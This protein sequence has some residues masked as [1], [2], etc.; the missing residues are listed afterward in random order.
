MA[1]RAE[2]DLDHR[3]KCRRLRDEIREF[4]DDHWQRFGRRGPETEQGIDHIN[5][6]AETRL[7]DLA[8]FALDVERLMA[9][10]IQVVTVP[11][12]KPRIRDRV[13]ASAV[14]L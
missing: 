2:R 4:I 11:G 13:V 8:G 6:G 9:V 10:F 14:P 3:G 5:A 12:L 7:F 1:A